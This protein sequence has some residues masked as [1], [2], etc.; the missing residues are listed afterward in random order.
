MDR[1][2]NSRDDGIGTAE[3]APLAHPGFRFERLVAR[4]FE[5]KGFQAEIARRVAS[6]NRPHFIEV[7]VVLTWNGE[8]RTVVEVKLYRTRTPNP[9]DLNRAA[10][11]ALHAQESLPADHAMVV[12]NLD[13]HR[14]PATELPGGAI[15]VGFEDLVNWATG[16]P[17]LLSELMDIDRELSSALRDFDRIP[18]LLSTDA[19]LDLSIVQSAGGP[20]PSR[21]PAQTLKGRGLADELRE[22]EQHLGMTKVV[23]LKS[24]RKGVPWRLYEDLCYEGLQYVFEG[25]LNGW[26]KQEPVAG[27]ANRFD[28]LAKITG[29]DVFS[30]TLIEDFRSRYILFEFKFYADPVGANLIHITEKYLYPAALRGCAIIVSPKGLAGPA[31]QACHGAMR[32]AGK[33]ILNLQTADLCQILEEKDGGTQPTE[34]MEQRLDAFLL[35]IGR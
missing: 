26:R 32:E 33:L 17:A 5:A 29:D 20:Q 7:D 16:D 14:M 11:H 35:A 2:L 27:D 23:S 12:T 31:T 34:G 4:I 15:L 19:G 1:P 18:D 10:E 9:A 6:N 21:A 8:V 3:G 25:L 30:R 13:R 22:L 24:G 28:A